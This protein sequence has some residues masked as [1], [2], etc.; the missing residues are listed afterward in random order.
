MANQAET[1]IREAD[2]HIML[3]TAFLCKFLTPRGI[4]AVQPSPPSTNTVSAVSGRPGTP[5][6]PAPLVMDPAAIT[7]AARA[8]AIAWHA[9]SRHDEVVKLVAGAPVISK[10]LDVRLLRSIEES[11][12]GSLLGRDDLRKD[13]RAAFWATVKALA[14]SPTISSTTSSQTGS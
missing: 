8:F 4:A 10:P 6:L 1:L 11:V 2:Q 12:G 9:G 5:A 14:S 7:A 3:P 13:A